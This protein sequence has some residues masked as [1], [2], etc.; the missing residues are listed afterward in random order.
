[1]VSGQIEF[2][3]CYLTTLT[4]LN[5]PLSI[6]LCTE[7]MDVFVQYMY[8]YSTRLM[9]FIMIVFYAGI[10]K[11]V[12]IDERQKWSK[13]YTKPSVKNVVTPSLYIKMCIYVI[14]TN[15][16]FKL[17]FYFVVCVKENISLL[18]LRH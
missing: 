7:W 14:L 16:C 1:M 17:H 18:N 2:I 5:S 4:V 12:D 13:T 15:M 10:P 6:L 11:Q 9:Y 3:I 8:V